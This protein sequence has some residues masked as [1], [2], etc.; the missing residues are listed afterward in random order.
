MEIR[1]RIL[2]EVKTAM[3][4]KN[5]VRV[6][7]LRGIQSAIKNKEIELRPNPISGDDILNV[8]KKLVKQRKESIEQFLAAKRQDLVDKESTELKILEEFLPPQLSVADIEALVA[9]TI[10]EVGAT[11]VKDMGKVMKAVMAKT[12]GAADN[13]VV[14]EA[15]KSKLN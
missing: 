3:K 2:S 13:K 1:D 10:T 8:L 11:S 5:Q 12:Q 4:D 9:A 14:S 15:I 7:T 6:D